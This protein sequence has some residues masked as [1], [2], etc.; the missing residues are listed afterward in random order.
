MTRISMAQTAEG[1]MT[2]NTS[3]LNRMRDLSLQSAN[4][5][6]TL[7]DRQA[8]QKEVDSLVAEVDRIAETTNFAGI[9]LLDGTA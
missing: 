8:M 1:A 6:N 5:T 2:E 4:D 9:N 7:E 3:I